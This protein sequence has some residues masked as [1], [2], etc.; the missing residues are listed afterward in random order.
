MTETATS[1]AVTPAA[2][3]YSTP[4][5]MARQPRAIVRVQGSPLPGWVGVEIDNNTHQQT[6]TFRVVYA[7]NQGRFVGEP[8][9]TPERA[10]WLTGQ[11]RIQVEILIGFPADPGNYGASELQSMIL[12]YADSMNFD[13][14]KGTIELNGRDMAGEFLDAKTSETFTNQGPAAIVQTLAARHGLSVD[15][16][17]PGGIDGTFY[18]IDHR[19]INNA[20]SEWDL[21]C[22][23]AG[24]YNR[25]V[26]VD[27]NTLRFKSADSGLG[28]GTY[29]IK[30]MP[31]DSMR[32]YPMANVIEMRFTRNNMLGKG[33]VNVTVQSVH[34]KQKAVFSSTATAAKPGVTDG[35][36]QSYTY[37]E[38]G[39]TADQVQKRANTRLNDIMMNEMTLSADL[40]GD[41][42]LNVRSV[43]VVS[44]TGTAF[45][46]AY[47]PATSGTNIYVSGYTF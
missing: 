3:T 36:E 34:A 23:L 4:Q 25:K 47:Y 22:E 1:M 42:M 28:G 29:N 7:I 32:G 45:D 46:Q 18:E 12:G 26:W 41:N 6:D 40:P 31:P 44:G 8:G 19:R 10:A 27:G 17:D 20:A 33:K 13:P 37:N 5:P 39:L 2:A 35:S 43:V 9:L 11:S 15:I 14:V 30:W 16:D 38:P 24:D 21:L